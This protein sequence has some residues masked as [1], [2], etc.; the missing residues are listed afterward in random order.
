MDLTVLKFCGHSIAQNDV[1]HFDCEET[2]AYITSKLPLTKV[3]WTAYYEC[4]ELRVQTSLYFFLAHDYIPT[5]LHLV[6]TYMNYIIIWTRIC[7]FTIDQML[8]VGNYASSEQEMKL[9]R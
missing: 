4:L 7:V 2:I 5:Q 9:F 8:F 6:D 3:A 1:P